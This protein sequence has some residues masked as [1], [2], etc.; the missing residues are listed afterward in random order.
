[1]GF[2]IGGY[3]SLSKQ[4]VWGTATTSRVYIPFISESLTQNKEQL[5]SEN[6]K[7]VYDQPDALEGINNVTGDI[8]FEPHP[9]VLGEFLQSAVGVP[10]STLQT[11][12]YLHE[13]LP[14]Q[15]DWGTDGALTP[16]TIEIYKNVGSAY[17][18]VDAQIHTLAI[19]LTA[20]AIVKATATVHGRA[21][22]KVAKQTASYIDSKPFTWNQCSLEVA[23]SANSN[24]ESATITITNPV[25]GI[26]MLN[27][28]T[29]EGRVLRTG[30]R[31]VSVTGEQDFSDQAEEGIFINQTRQRFRFSVTGGTTVGNTGEFNQ[32]VM[33]LPQVNYSTYTYPIGG[34]GRVVASYEGNAEY[35]TTSSYAIRYTL[36]N[37]SSSY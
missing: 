20:G 21:Y 31:T 26:P 33:D 11:S 36:Q 10:T 37:T 6:I 35:N 12:A 23:G 24:F 22:S 32:L 27:N 1:M 9:I 34:A 16:Y 8:A 18:V 3:L 2:G 17:Q 19:E 28:S 25:E 29:S 7:T 14:R 15:A 5:F 30:F 13:F 4:T